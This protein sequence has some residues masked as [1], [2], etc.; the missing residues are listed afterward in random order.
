MR[1]YRVHF[2]IDNGAS[3][4]FSW[5]SSRANALKAAREAVKDNPDDYEEFPQI[6]QVWVEMSRRGALS[7]LNRYAN[8]PDNV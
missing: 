8:H 4:G 3:A 1:L 5:H 6:E 7:A 2:L